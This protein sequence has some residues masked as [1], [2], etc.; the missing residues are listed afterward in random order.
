[1]NLKRFG[2]NLPFHPQ[3]GRDK[4]QNCRPKRRPQTTEHW[5]IN[6]TSMG[7]IICDWG[8]KFSGLEVLVEA[9]NYWPSI[10]FIIRFPVSFLALRCGP[11]KGPLVSP[12]GSCTRTFNRKHAN[13]DSRVITTNLDLKQH[14]ELPSKH[15]G[16][17]K[18]IEDYSSNVL[19]VPWRLSSNSTEMTYKLSYTLN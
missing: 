13:I 4:V 3:V 19:V 7:P 18:H 8:S 2:V 9:Q 12:W 1:M 6:A 11:P 15:I 16:A 10:T 5:L 17:H 14:T